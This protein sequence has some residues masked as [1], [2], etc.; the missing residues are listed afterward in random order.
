MITFQEIIR[1]LSHFWEQQGC[2]I[3][4]GYDMEIGAGTFN[5]GP[6]FCAA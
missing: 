2:I 6:P 4:Q 3:H 1:R 5:P